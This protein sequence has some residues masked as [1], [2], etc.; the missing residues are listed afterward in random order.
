M[1]PPTTNDCG[2][3]VRLAMYVASNGDKASQ[4]KL[5]DE[6]ISTN[7]CTPRLAQTAAYVP[8]DNNKGMV[9]V[10]KDVDRASGRADYHSTSGCGLEWEGVQSFFELFAVDVVRV[11]IRVEHCRSLAYRRRSFTISPPPAQ[12]CRVPQSLAQAG[13]T[14]D[15]HQ[16]LL[17]RVHPERGGIQQQ[18]R[19]N[20]KSGGFSR[21]IW[22]GPRRTSMQRDSV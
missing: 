22:T 6:I 9:N 18:S 21:R 10:C 8:F 14:H 5:D 2:A 20:Y 7:G 15:G 13:C 11:Y 19:R 3:A 4:L 17:E 12:H 1:R 16:P